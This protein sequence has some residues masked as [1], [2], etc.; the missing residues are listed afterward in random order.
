[1]TAHHRPLLERQRRAKSEFE[2]LSMRYDHNLIID[3]F[4]SRFREKLNNL[5]RAQLPKNPQ[6]LLVEIIER[7]PPECSSHILL[8]PFRTADG[9]MRPAA[10]AWEAGEMARHYYSVCV[11]QEA[12]F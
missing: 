9:Q 10:T 12:V 4:L 3:D 2:A 1:M 6:E 8:T 5:L 11:S 7:L